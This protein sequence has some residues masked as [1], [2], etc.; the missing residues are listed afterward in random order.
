MITCV[1]VNPAQRVSMSIQDLDN[2]RNLQRKKEKI[3]LVFSPSLVPR[4][5]GNEASPLM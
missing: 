2:L 5:P 4:E 3:L 1:A